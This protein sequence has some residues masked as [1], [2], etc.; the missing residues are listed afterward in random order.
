MTVILHI[1]EQ[2][3]DYSE[4]IML[5]RRVACE[6]EC[7]VPIAECIPA[8]YSTTGRC[9][10]TLQLQPTVEVDDSREAIEPASIGVSKMCPITRGQTASVKSISK[11]GKHL[12]SVSGMAS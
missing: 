6:S 1:C 10:M 2:L 4:H 7:M 11:H 8:S 5:N 3:F 9:S 12:C